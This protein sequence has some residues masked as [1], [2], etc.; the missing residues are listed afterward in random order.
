M[1]DNQY[2]YLKTIPVTG[3]AL[4]RIPAHGPRRTSPRGDVTGEEKGVFLSR[5]SPA[6]GQSRVKPRPTTPG[7]LYC[8]HVPGSR[9]KLTRILTIPELA[10]TD[11]AICHHPL[12]AGMTS[13]KQMEMLLSSASPADGQSRVKTSKT[14]R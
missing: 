2:G 4:T 1:F 5:A 8:T 6:D 7:P 10:N 13:G 3:L 11:S 9:G 12:Q 14:R